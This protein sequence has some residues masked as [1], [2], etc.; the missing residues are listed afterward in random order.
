M[1][2]HHNKVMGFP[3]SGINEIPQYLRNKNTSMKKNNYLDVSLL[4]Q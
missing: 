3:F 4:K 1:E 2:G